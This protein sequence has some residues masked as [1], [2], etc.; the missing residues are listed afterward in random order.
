MDKTSEFISY[1]KLIIFGSEGSGKTTLKSSIETGVYSEQSH[2]ED[3][4]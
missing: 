3:G 2:T 4:K 1:K